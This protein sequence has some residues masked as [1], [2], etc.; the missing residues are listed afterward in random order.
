[1][2]PVSM[3][4]LA[5]LAGG[6]GGELGRQA[7][8]ALSEL[9]RR[10]FGGQ[11]EAAAPGEAELAALSEAPGEQVRAEALSGA[12]AAR[13]VVDPEFAAALDS[14][15]GRVPALVEGSVT[16]TVSG[17]TQYGSVIQGRDFSGITFS[18]PG[19]PPARETRES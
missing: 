6:A 7:W 17:G 19:V 9:V 15:R 1:M 11:V 4:V 12:L 2:D 16:N 5:A 14:W 3:G 10:P 18:N 13:A 8:A